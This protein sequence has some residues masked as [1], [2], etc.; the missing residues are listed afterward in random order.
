MIA[1][2]GFA[3]TKLKTKQDNRTIYEISALEFFLVSPLI[4]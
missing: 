1:L 4:K 2:V 3:K